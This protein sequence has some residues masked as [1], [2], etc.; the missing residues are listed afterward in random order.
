M[1]SRLALGANTELLHLLVQR[2]ATDPQDAGGFSAVVISLP[3]G[4]ENK[5]ALSLLDR[6]R[7]M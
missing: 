5:F 7:Q 4:L 3:K 1:N 2:V 6:G